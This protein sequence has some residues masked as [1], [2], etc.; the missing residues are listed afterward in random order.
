MKFL[1][2]NKREA[3]EH[4]AEDNESHS[5]RGKL[6]GIDG[7]ILFSDLSPEGTRL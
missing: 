6:T 2:R 4:V 7:K 1:P 5:H 3:F